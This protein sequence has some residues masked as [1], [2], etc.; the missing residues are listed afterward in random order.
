MSARLARRSRARP[1]QNARQ[2]LQ[3]AAGTDVD[4]Q[5][6]PSLQ[7]SDLQVIFEPQDVPLRQLMSQ[8]QAMP[9]LMLV[10]ELVPVHSTS[11][12][13]VLHMNSLQLWRPEQVTLQ[14]LPPGQTRP[15][16]HEPVT[17]HR[18]LQFQPSGHLIGPLHAP[19]LTM[20]S[21][22][23]V[24]LSLL[25]EVHCCGQRFASIGGDDA[26]FFMPSTGTL[27]SAC[28]ATQKLSMQVRPVLQSA[29]FSQAKSPLR[30][31]TE[32]PATR[33][34]HPT[35]QRAVTFMACLRS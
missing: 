7:K 3:V 1:G 27:A 4:V 5:P 13:P 9:Q 20:Q 30:W 2:A 23:Q 6:R 24:L 15:L 22:V 17:E 33:S 34:A 16:L 8:A 28:S 21:I 32:Q 31:L 35:S 19:P 25:Q 26:S 11:H 18:T 10:H 29:C 12:A 14:D